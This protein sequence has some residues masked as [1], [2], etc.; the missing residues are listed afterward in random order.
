MKIL[1]LILI[2]SSLWAESHHEKVFTNY[3]KRGAWDE[4]GVSLSG[5][6]QVEV[7]REYM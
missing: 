2:C 1:T 6:S 4:K 3:Y 5:S 7:T